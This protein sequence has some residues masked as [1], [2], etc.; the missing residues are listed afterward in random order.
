MA[1]AYLY[2]GGRRLCRFYGGGCQECAAA[3]FVAQREKRVPPADASQSGIAGKDEPDG[4][5]TAYACHGDDVCV[6]LFCLYLF[7]VAVV[8]YDADRASG[9][10]R[11][12]TAADSEFLG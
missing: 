11:R 6:L 9:A 10:L 8:V 7:I 3:A 1:A 5:V 12:T 2:D 4:G